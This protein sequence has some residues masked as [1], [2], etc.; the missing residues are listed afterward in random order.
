ME[1]VDLG[2]YYLS[3][4]R[5]NIIKNTLSVFYFVFIGGFLLNMR[6]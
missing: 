5:E 6:N 4:P 3:Q 2:E 1:M